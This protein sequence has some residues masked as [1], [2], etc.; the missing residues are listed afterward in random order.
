[1]GFWNRLF[2]NKND[3]HT[4]P[5]TPQPVIAEPI[6]AN[7]LRWI[8]TRFFRLGCSRMRQK[9][10]T[11]VRTPKIWRLPPGRLQNCSTSILPTTTSAAWCQLR[12]LPPTAT[13]MLC[14]FIFCFTTSGNA[15]GSPWKS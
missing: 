2:R 11:D 5:P 15:Q 1:M 14:P 13:R 3:Q 9:R 7:R 10:V 6:P 12:P 4:T 8:R